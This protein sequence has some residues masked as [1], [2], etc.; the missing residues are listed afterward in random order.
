MDL[1]FAL[2]IDKVNEDGCDTCLLIKFIINL[3]FF[4]LI[5]EYN[6]NVCFTM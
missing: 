1:I 6:K 5:H 3:L 2:V 4:N